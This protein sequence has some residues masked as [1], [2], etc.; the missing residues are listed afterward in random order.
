MTQILRLERLHLG[1]FKL[2]FAG[3][4]A[5]LVYNI[6]SVTRSWAVEYVSLNVVVRLYDNIKAPKAIDVLV[7]VVELFERL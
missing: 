4:P 3:A 5:G 2:L 6:L 1:L 7:S